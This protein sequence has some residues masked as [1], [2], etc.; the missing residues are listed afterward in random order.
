[1]DK[2][3]DIEKSIKEILKNCEVKT[4]TV[5]MLKKWV[6]EESG[7]AMASVK[8]YQKKCLECFNKSKGKNINLFL[9]AIMDAWNYLPHGSLFGLSPYEAAMKNKIKIPS[10]HN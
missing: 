1:M 5:E 4:L 10:E 8:N 2:Q 7:P 3:K 6:Y 9:N